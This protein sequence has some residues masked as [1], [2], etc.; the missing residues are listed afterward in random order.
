MLNQKNKSLIWNAWQAG[1]QNPQNTPSILEGIWTTDVTYHGPYPFHEIQGRAAILEKV[2]QPLFNAFPDMH[3]RV[4]LFLGGKVGKDITKTDKPQHWVAGM[5]DYIG[6]FANDFLGIPPSGNKVGWR[7]M[8]F[9]TRKGDY[10]HEDWVLIDLIDAC[11][12]IGVDL[13]ERM[14]QMKP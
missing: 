11:R 6:T 2:W 12:Q 8:D 5:G 3:R 1:N 10:L 13:F 9:Y 7:I 4:Y 14:E